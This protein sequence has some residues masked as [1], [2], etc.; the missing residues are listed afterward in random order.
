MGVRDDGSVAGLPVTDHLLLQLADM[1]TDGNIVPL[2]SMTVE[3]RTLPDGDVAVVIVQPSDS[4]PVRCRGRIHI[5]IGPRR[6]I[7][8]AQDERILNE[9]RRFGDIPFDIYPVPSAM[10]PD[11]D[12]L[13]FEREYLA[14]AFTPDIL[15]SND[16]SIEEKL[17]ATNDG[18]IDGR[19]YPHNS[20]LACNWQKPSG[21][22]TWR[23]R[24][25]SPTGWHGSYGPRIGRRSNQWNHFRYSSTS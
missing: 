20:G 12:L 25:I 23:I 3:K 10:L 14:Q 2:P 18:C 24:P 17:A 11:L 16:R 13:Q 21:L 1:K 4:P 9:K 15:E 22:P 19:Y 5:R 6:G 8:T 7:A